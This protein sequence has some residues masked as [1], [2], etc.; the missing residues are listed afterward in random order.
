[1]LNASLLAPFSAGPRDD[2]QVCSFY[3]EPCTEPGHGAPRPG[4]RRTAC[5]LTLPLPLVAA[6]SAAGIWDFSEQRRAVLK[7]LQ[8]E[9]DIEKMAQRRVDRLLKRHRRGSHAYWATADSPGEYL[10]GH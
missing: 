1:M 6:G 10:A 2:G 9:A 7:M 4:Q 8:K 3:K 5:L